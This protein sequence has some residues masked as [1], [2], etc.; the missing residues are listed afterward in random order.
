MGLGA[1]LIT[2]S[3][4]TTI[5]SSDANTNWQNLN[6]AETFTG[7]VIIQTTLNINGGAYINFPGTG[8]LSNLNYFSGSGSG[9]FN[10]GMGTAPNAIAFGYAGNFGGAP[11]QAIFYYNMNSTNVVVNAQSGFSWLAMAYHA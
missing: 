10:H 3:P 4:N 11:S 6:N 2:V 7:D 1:S 9:T 5:K 8:S